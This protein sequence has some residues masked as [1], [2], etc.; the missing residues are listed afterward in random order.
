MSHDRPEANLLFAATSDLHMGDGS[1]RDDFGRAQ[2]ERLCRSVEALAPIFVRCPGARVVLVGDVCDAWRYD[3]GK[4][5]AAH[6]HELSL[7]ASMS[8]RP[9]LWMRGNHD[10]VLRRLDLPDHLDRRVVLLRDVVLGG[11]YIAHGDQW[12]PDPGVWRRVGVGACKALSWV[13]RTFGAGAENRLDRWASSLEGHGRHGKADR[14]SLA[15]VKAARA[16]FDRVGQAPVGVVFGH[17][18]SAGEGCIDGVEWVDLGTMPVDG[19]ALVWSDGVV[20]RV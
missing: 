8:S 9:V 1:P 3:L 13:G 6:E 19:W 2:S 14:Y 11:W 18:H 17:T 15:A 7:V 12:D 10:S 16:E 20:T 4:I 5:L